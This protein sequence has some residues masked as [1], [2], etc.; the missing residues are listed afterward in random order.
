MGKEQT[1]GAKNLGQGL[2]A[3]CT[4]GAVTVG[5]DVDLTAPTCPHWEAYAEKKYGPD[6][7][8]GKLWARVVERENWRN[9]ETLGSPEA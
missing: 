2:A 9:S 1:E 8:L 3:G 5:P 4:E 7:Y 6:S